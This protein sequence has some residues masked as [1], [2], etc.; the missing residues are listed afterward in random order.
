M[1][2]ATPA[3]PASPP[4]PPRLRPPATRFPAAGLVYPTT[5][6][7]WPK[8]PV[9]KT[10]SETST[11]VSLLISAGHA[12]VPQRR[13]GFVPMIASSESSHP[14]PSVSALRQ[15]SLPLSSTVLD[16]LRNCHE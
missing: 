9:R 5:G 8:L 4:R 12:F 6:R 14:S 1:P 13:F 15:E 11:N 10:M 7:A 2:A 16:V 3:A